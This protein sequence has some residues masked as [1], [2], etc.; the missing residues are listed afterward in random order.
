MKNLGMLT[1]HNEEVR[2]EID[3]GRG[4]DI[5]S[6]KHLGTGVELLFSTPWRKRADAIRTGDTELTSLDPTAIWLEGYRGGW[7]T[8]LPNAGAARK[9]G[10]VVVGFHGEASVINWEVEEVGINHARLSARL[11]S[12]PIAVERNISLRGSRIEFIDTLRN[13]GIAPQEF[14]YV[15]HAAFGGQFLEGECKIDTGASRFVLDPEHNG[16]LGEAGSVHE[17]PLLRGVNA[18][19]LDLSAIP[20]SSTPQ[21]LLG[22]LEN[23]SDYWISI[24]NS[25]LALS[26]LLEWD[27]KYLPFAWLWEEL[28][29]SAEFPWFGQARVIGTE[30]ASTQTSGPM[31]RSVINLLPGESISIPISLT[32]KSEP[33]GDAK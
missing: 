31:R 24:V 3:P 11:F 27:G 30:P 25:T 17:W 14:D 6:I 18:T 12:V 33:L 22:W 5:L 15:S 28:N 20:D 1:L 13:F 21:A 7:Q 16:S 2:I 4:A 32:I 26:I 23:F 19:V 9:F 10:E 29:G 8:L